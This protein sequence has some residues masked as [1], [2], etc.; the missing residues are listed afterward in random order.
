MSFGTSITQAAVGQSPGSNHEFVVGDF[1]GEGR[2]ELATHADQRGSAVVLR[3]DTSLTRVAELPVGPLAA[4]PRIVPPTL[5]GAPLL[6]LGVDNPGAPGDAFVRYGLHPFDGGA[7]LYQWT[8][9]RILGHAVADLDGDGR[10]ELYTGSGP[11]ARRLRQIA[12]GPDGQWQL[13]APHPPTDAAGSDLQSIEAGDL[14]GDG[15]PE[16]VVVA[17]PWSAYDLRVLKADDDGQLRL[18]ARRSLG[19]IESMVLLRMGG[20]LR[21]AAAKRDEYPAPGRFSEARPYGEPAGL[22]ILALDG[23]TLATRQFIPVPEGAPRGA[24]ARWLYNGDFDGDGV[25]DLLALAPPELVLYRSDGEA[26]I[27][28][29]HLSGLY[30]RA[31][32]NFDDDPAAEL[33]VSLP[34]APDSYFIVGAGNVPLPPIA[35]PAPEARPI[36]DVEDPALVDAW[37]HA[38]ELAALGL[39]RRSADELAAIARLSGHA[40]EDMLLRAADLYAT[41]GE[42]AAAAEHYLAAAARPDLA[43]GALAGAIASRRELGDYAAALGL[44]IRRAALPGLDLKVR[45][46]AEAEPRHPPPRHRRAPPARAPLRPPARLRLA[47]LRPAVVLP[48]PGRSEPGP[49]DI[50]GAAHRRVPARVGRRHRGPD[51]RRRAR[52]PRVGHQPGDRGHPRRQRQRLPRRPLRVAQ[53]LR[54]ARPGGLPD[55]RTERRDLLLGRHDPARR[56]APLPRRHAPLPRPRHHSPRDRPGRRRAAARPVEAP[57]KAAAARPAAPA[58][59]QSTCPTGQRRRPAGVRGRA[60]RPAPRRPAPGSS[61]ARGRP[62]GR[63]G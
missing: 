13:R 2:R 21:I 39:P 63:R 19:F 57:D 11:Y 54:A 22:Y 29:L 45:R 43:A 59:A 5:S 48:Q 10:P 46:E 34:G 36:G 23:D 33:L 53:P 26:L 31:V 38:E 52:R 28:P 7:P 1:D 51:R 3:A 62:P 4:S 15:R 47:D 37:R 6:L 49:S 8:E 40:H 24:G 50:L 35:R 18:L 30:L 32:T 61:V 20:E 55:H 27:E 60:V 41:A 12:P 58:G 14:D 56:G 16:L 17:G 9:S 44:A 42:H 25:D